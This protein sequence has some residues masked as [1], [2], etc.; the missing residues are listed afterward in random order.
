MI[1]P[2]AQN[3]PANCDNDEAIA[4][5]ETGLATF[6]QLM[7][8]LGSLKTDDKPEANNQIN[9]NPELKVGG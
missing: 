5:L 8:D 3:V 6:R 7:T 1:T 9:Q 2:L 4:K